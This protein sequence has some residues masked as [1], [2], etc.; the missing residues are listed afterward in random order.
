MLT[1]VDI[2]AGLVSTADDMSPATSK[3]VNWLPDVA[4]V[5]RIRPA[6]VSYPTTGLGTAP[7]IGLYRWKTW[8]IG[9]DSDRLIYALPDLTPAVWLALSDP[10]VATTKLAGVG[11]PVFAE[12]PSFLYIAGGLAIQKWTGIGLSARLAGT[13]PNTTHIVNLAQRLV[14]PSLAN[15]GRYLYSDAGEGNDS[16]WGALN[17]ETAEA[18]PDTLVAIAENTA[19][20]GLFGSS[21]TEIHGIST[22]PL[23]PFQ[24]ISTMNVGCSA[25]YSIVRFDNYYFW[26]DDKRRIVKSD[27]RSYESVGDAIQRDLRDLG[28][29]SDAW[30]YREDTDRNGCLVWTFPSEGRTWAYDYTAQ[31][32]SE[33]ALYDGVS[34]NTAWPVA[35]HA[36]WD[37]QNANIVGASTTAGLYQLDTDTRQDIGGT[38]LAE[39]V[40]GWQ[41]FGTD[42]RKRSARVRVV[43]RRGTTPLGNT[44]GQLEV[45]VED[46]G[47]GFTP[48]RVID[49][50]Q[51][52]DTQPSIDCHFGGVFR[53]RR[54]WLRYSG[55]D[56]VSIAKL[57]DDVTDLEAAA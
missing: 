16:T 46:D 33:R 45:A 44:S 24:R 29:V 17:F 40:T 36:F 41:D 22:D 3:L 37:A 11:R 30:G 56:E 2:S 49:L 18:R 10:A 5:Q 50:G 20:L 12:S 23:I 54:Y 42:N 25:P 34:T 35:T 31:K 55:I 38:I 51:P 6:L 8:V 9:V 57:A 28:T 39:L 13:S 52:Y 48:F 27:G 7:L 53:R 14:A 26:L 4:G 19:E 47:K 21:T 32:W 43:M 1:A 15:P